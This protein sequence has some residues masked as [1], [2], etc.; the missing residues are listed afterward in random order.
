MTIEPGEN[1]KI[2]VD[3]NIL[4]REN[5]TLDDW[6][7]VSENHIRALRYKGPIKY[8]KNG[9]ASLAEPTGSRFLREVA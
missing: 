5:V 2:I 1:Y 4:A 7:R 9:I 8:D 3:N 6:R